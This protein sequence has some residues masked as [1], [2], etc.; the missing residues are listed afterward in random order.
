M[1]FLKN[2]SSCPAKLLHSLT[3]D[4]SII[5]LALKLFCYARARRETQ[6]SVVIDARMDG[7]LENRIWGNQIVKEESGKEKHGLKGRD[8]ALE[9]EAKSRGRNGTKPHPKCIFCD[10]QFLF[11]IWFGLDCI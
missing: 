8:G 2:K 10:G 6:V 5:Y 1:A 3:E 4:P 7:D 9:T 11:L